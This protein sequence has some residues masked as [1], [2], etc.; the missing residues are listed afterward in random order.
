ME[1]SPHQERLANRKISL[2]GRRGPSID[3]EDLSS[4]ISIVSSRAASFDRNGT[5]RV[6][7]ELLRANGA[8]LGNGSAR[9]S[10]LALAEAPSSRDDEDIELSSRH[11]ASGLQAKSGIIIVWTIYQDLGIFTELD[12]WYSGHS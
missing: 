7:A 5:P 4:D 8:L 6:S 12:K 10:H 3:D 1:E 11:R 2:E 9:Q